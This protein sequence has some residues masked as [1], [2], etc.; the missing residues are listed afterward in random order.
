M[1]NG[2]TFEEILKEISKEGQE[3][4]GKEFGR[5]FGKDFGHEDKNERDFKSIKEYLKK[6]IDSYD[7]N[8]FKSAKFY[9]D[10]ILKINPE[11]KDALK[12]REK[13]K[14]VKGI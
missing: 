7:I 10:K 5:I 6:G 11:N 4:I 13:V 14:R 9:F 12:W 8:D 2:Q 1:E 3:R